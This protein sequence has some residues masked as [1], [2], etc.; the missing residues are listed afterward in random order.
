MPLLLDDTI[1]MNFCE[2]QLVTWRDPRFGECKEGK[3]EG[4]DNLE[5]VSP[6]APLSDLIHI[7][8]GAGLV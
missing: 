7:K 4:G 1:Q 5:K 3:R 8:A 6:L 2:R